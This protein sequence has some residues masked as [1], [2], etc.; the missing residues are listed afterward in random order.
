MEENDN[1]QIAVDEP[2]SKMKEFCGEES[3]SMKFMKKRVMEHFGDDVI[4]TEINSRPNVVTFRST[5][6]SI[7]H[8]FY[9]LPIQQDP[10]S[11]KL[12][13]IETA[14]NLIKNG[15]KIMDTSKDI[16]PSPEDIGSVKK[17]LN[18]SQS[19]YV[20]FQEKCSLKRVIQL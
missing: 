10:E 16:Y 1:E 7:L 11:E 14:A 4:I 6:A 15:I 13:I 9:D 17:I 2:F 3:Y 8:K 12:R 18:L 19:H 5:A 20:S